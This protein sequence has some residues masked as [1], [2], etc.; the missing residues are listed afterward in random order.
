MKLDHLS[1][2][3]LGPTTTRLRFALRK[4][5]PTTAT[6]RDSCAGKGCSGSHRTPICAHSSHPIRGGGPNGRHR[7][8]V[9]LRP[10][11]PLEGHA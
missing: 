9:G 7:V 6:R 11:D 5:R 10:G 2:L 4:L 3:I 1:S 8:V